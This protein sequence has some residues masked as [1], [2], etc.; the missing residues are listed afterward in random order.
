MRRAVSFDFN[1]IEPSLS[2][3]STTTA[4]TRA[5]F[6]RICIEIMGGSK[7]KQESKCIVVGLDGSGKS[8]IIN[9]LKPEKKKV[10]DFSSQAATN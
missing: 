5:F 6:G 4:V 1:A 8:T 10:G 7:S 2:R 3:A 9:Q